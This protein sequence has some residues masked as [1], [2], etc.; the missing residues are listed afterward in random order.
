MSQI[1]DK[2]KAFSTGH[3]RARQSKASHQNF[4][5]KLLVSV[6]VL[7]LIY[8][9]GAFLGKLDEAEKRALVVVV[10]PNGGTLRGTLADIPSRPQLIELKAWAAGAVDRYESAGTN[11]LDEH[12]T[13]L[14]GMMSREGAERF[15]QGLGGEYV[16]EERLTARMHRSVRIDFDRG[17]V[18]QLTPDD[19]LRSKTAAEGGIREGYDLYVSGVCLKQSLTSDYQRAERFA[20]WVRLVDLEQGRVAQAPHGVA[21]D[22][23]RP[24]V[25]LTAKEEQGHVAHP[26][27]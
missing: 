20:Y 19:L 11:N 3:E 14:R 1:A 25:P 6:L 15:D 17:D 23:L 18:R 27:E 2:I 9:G 12:F 16:R 24:L 21:V 13:R 4:F 26:T 5:L 8:Q 10:G 7:A 22:D